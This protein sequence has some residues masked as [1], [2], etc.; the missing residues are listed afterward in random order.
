MFC[1]SRFCTPAPSLG[2][3][4]RCPEQGVPRLGLYNTN[5]GGGGGYV[6]GRG[7][8]S[9]LYRGP[10][11][12]RGVHLSPL[13]ATPTPSLMCSPPHHRHVRRQNST[14]PG[15][16]SRKSVNFISS[17]AAS[18]APILMSPLVFPSLS[19]AFVLGALLLSPSL[20][21]VRPRK[22]GWGRR[23]G[24]RRTAQLKSKV[25]THAPERRVPQSGA[26]AGR[27][28]HRRESRARGALR[29]GQNDRFS[30][31]VFNVF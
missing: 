7:G 9:A 16:P 30:L 24:V 29:R 11:P 18:R 28:A 23:T 12:K 5:R 22:G 4:F 25:D 8:L 21:I 26:S 1:G 14:R 27:S 6:I 19:S 3:I 2:T 13:M 10:S 31:C 20:I 17:R 15:A